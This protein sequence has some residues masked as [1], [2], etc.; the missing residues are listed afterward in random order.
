MTDGN[1]TVTLTAAASGFTS[2][3]S[4]LVVSDADLPDLVVHNVSAPASARTDEPL[5]IS[6]RLDNQGHVATGSNFVQRILLSTDGVIGGDMWLGQV[7]FA[8]TIQPGSG[9][10]QTVQAVAPHTP[11][12]YYVVVVAD[13]NDSIVELFEGNNDA[14]RL[15]PLHIEP[16]YTATI[17]ADVHEAPT[18]TTVPLHGVAAR[19]STGQPAA[20]VPIN[21]HLVVRGIER[22]FSVVTDATGAFSM[23]FRPLPSAAGAYTVAAAHPGVREPAPQDTFTLYGMTISSVPEVRVSEGSFTGGS[24][25]VEN[26][27]DIPLT[28]L[29][30]TVLS[31]PPNLTVTASL[32]SNSLPGDATMRLGYVVTAPVGTTTGGP[33]RLRINSA[34][35]VSADLDLRI[36]VAPLTPDLQVTPTSL[37]AGMSRAEQSM[38]QFAVTNTG[39]GA[40][41]PIHVVLPGWAW[42]TVAS[43][44]VLPSLEPGD[45]TQVS[46]LLSPPADLPLG[47]VPAARSFWRAATRAPMCPSSLSVSRS[48]W[49]TCE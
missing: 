43:G 31:N 12:D 16:A 26:L 1:Q 49:E 20:A 13:A 22:V 7:T 3:S 34:E 40:S 18:G 6:F 24:A 41:G 2:G 45:G 48:A 5:S 29:S 23:E 30:V 42:L 11:G 15:T 39:G 28:D 35:G 21:V 17:T 25:N 9:A 46:L 47:P 10:S 33:A 44:D 19:A 37:F 32:S 27:S 38:V 4:V 36:S 14:I 8:G